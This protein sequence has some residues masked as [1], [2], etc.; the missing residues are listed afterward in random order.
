MPRSD[1]DD[2]ENTSPGDRKLTDEGPRAAASLDRFFEAYYR[3]RPVNATFIGSHEHD[4]RWPDYSENGAGDTRAEM[5]RQLG[6]LQALVT[7]DRGGLSRETQL[8]LRLATGYLRTQVW[9]FESTHFHRGNPSLYVGE[10]AFGLISLFL[11]E[12][13]PLADRVGSAT[14]RMAGLPDFLAQARQNIRAAPVPWT[15]RALREC[16]G[17]QALLG[18]GLGQLIASW[19][20]SDLPRRDIDRLESYRSRAARALSEFESY[21]RTD[22]DVPPSEVCSAGEDAFRMYL[23]EG[24]FVDLDPEELVRYANDAAREAS[25]DLDG[26]D[27]GADQRLLEDQRSTV[28]TYYA[29]YQALWDEVRSVAE[30]EDLLTWPD[31]PIRYVPRPDWTRAAAPDLYFL[32]YRSPAAFSRP[33]VHQYLVT[34]IEAGMPKAEQEQLLRQNHDAVI[35]LNHVVH[36]GSIGH[37][38]QNWH[39][40]RSK[41]RVGQMAAVDCASRIAMFCGGTMAEGWACY[42]TDLMRDAGFLTPLEERLERRGR[43]RMCTRALVDVRLHLGQ[44]TLAEAARTYEEKAGMSPGAA[45]AEAVKNSMFPGAAAMYLLGTDRIHSLRGE[46]SALLGSDFNLRGFHD[47]FLSYGSVPVSLIADDMV[48]RANRTHGSGLDRHAS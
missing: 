29:R 13:G 6:D 42:A 10:A 18:E 11:T 23:G 25:A 31:F 12:F 34:P 44:I 45:G 20:G 40:A 19:E 37:H 26:W 4:G 1:P 21:L 17:A 46:M 9:E 2:F 3:R 33:A 28:D 15:E 43:I 47:D 38:V 5:V 48:A 7:E 14:E 39:A 36:H 24:H 27:A 16:R 32:F 8:D 41:S 35:K 22:V 30:A